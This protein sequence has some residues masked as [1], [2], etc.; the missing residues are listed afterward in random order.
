MICVETVRAFEKVLVFYHI[1]VVEIVPCN[2]NSIPFSVLHLHIVPHMSRIGG[3][4]VVSENEDARNAEFVTD[5]LET[6]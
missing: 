4:A 6:L 5:K 2:V 1:I 3:A